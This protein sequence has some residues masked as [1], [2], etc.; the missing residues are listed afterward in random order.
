[1]KFL[2]TEKTIFALRTIFLLKV[3]ENANCPPEV[4]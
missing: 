3:M 4:K 1:M 2:H